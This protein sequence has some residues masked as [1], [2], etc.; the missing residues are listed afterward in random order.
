[1]DWTKILF[2]IGGAL[3]VFMAVRIIRTHPRAFSKKNIGKSLY[4]LGLLTLMIIGVVAF[5]VLM[6]RN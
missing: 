5:S 4:T 2:I 1:M 3:M 6:L